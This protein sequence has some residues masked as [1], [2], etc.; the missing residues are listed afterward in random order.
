VGDGAFIDR[1][2]NTIDVCLVMDTAKM[3]QKY[4]TFLSARH[5]GMNRWDA[6]DKI[7][8]DRPAPLG[9]LLVFL[10]FVPCVF[11]IMVLMIP[12]VILR[13]IGLWRAGQGVVQLACRICL[14]NYRPVSDNDRQ[15]DAACGVWWLP[16]IRRG[17][18]FWR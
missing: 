10:R 4:K 5:C 7:V 3:A 1:D 9:W 11:T 16:I 15:T 14:K 2:F 12:L 18:I 8:L 13:W 6:G 17:W